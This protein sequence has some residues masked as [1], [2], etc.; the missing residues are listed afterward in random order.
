[1]FLSLTL[2]GF[3]QLLA[4]KGIKYKGVLLRPAVAP[5]TVAATDATASEKAQ[6]DYIC[7]GANDEVQWV[8]A[9][10]AA[11]GGIVKLLGLTYNI[12]N[13]IT[14]TSHFDGIG[15]VSN[16]YGTKV[17]VVGE[18]TITLHFPGNITNMRISTAG[19][20]NNWKPMVK[21]EVI[22]STTPYDGQTDLLNNIFLKCNNYTGKG[23]VLYT[24]ATA[25]GD[26]NYMSFNTFGNIV[27]QEFS[28]NMEIKSTET[29]GSSFFNSNTFTSLQLT[30]ADTML[31]LNEV[32]GEIGANI[33]SAVNMQ[34]RASTD[35]GI[36]LDEGVSYN[37][38][39]AVYGMDWTSVPTVQ[40][41]GV[42]T[43][44]NSIFGFIPVIS[45]SA[46]GA[47]AGTNN[48]TDNTANILFP[49]KGTVTIAGGVLYING[50]GEYLVAGEAGNV[51]NLNYI[52]GGVKGQVIILRRAT[53]GDDITITTSMSD[54]PKAFVLRD[55][56]DFIMLENK[57]SNKW[58]PIQYYIDNGSIKKTIKRTIGWHGATG[59]DFLQPDVN[60][61]TVYPINIGAV[62]P[63]KAR[64]TNIQ[65]INIETLVGSGL[66]EILCTVGNATGG[67][68][69]ITSNS[70]DDIN[71][72]LSSTAVLTDAVLMNAAAETNIWIGFD[73][74]ANW[75][76]Y[77]A[78]KWA[79]YIT[80]EDYY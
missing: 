50:Q 43:T 6:A 14:L 16:I 3:G 37:Q 21:M 61:S 48:I 59:V 56:D 35:V 71:E 39:P 64:V 34:C 49:V 69:F 18:K 42:N 32:G 8:L 26:F 2:A 27:I 60:N 13:D 57:G 29:A 47:N 75:D 9:N 33:F 58:I 38:F 46:G 40:L 68:Q 70:C 77:T 23:L 15:G 5:I 20:T 63:V 10:T 12:Q 36:Y 45:W 22:A 74:D 80:F 25:A 66:H 30:S 55:A 52:Y 28:T 44:Y 65:V 78:G 4:P 1:M 51:D 7:D 72:V 41:G 53:A 73:P 17:V 19:R 31:L 76:T 67:A 54:I 11:A 62:I 79:I 24:Q